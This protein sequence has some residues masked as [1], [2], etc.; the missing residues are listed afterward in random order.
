MHLKS[1]ET[2]HEERN[3]K[4]FARM[5]AQFSLCFK[6]VVPSKLDLKLRGSTKIVGN[7]FFRGKK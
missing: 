7:A 3:T 2:L 6:T 5:I 4:I 1:E